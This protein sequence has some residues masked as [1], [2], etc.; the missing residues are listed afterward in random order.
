MDYCNS[1]FKY[2]LWTWIM[3]SCVHVSVCPC[4]LNAM[5]MRTE[6]KIVM[7]VIFKTLPDHMDVCLVSTWCVWRLSAKWSN[8]GLT[9]APPPNDIFSLPFSSVRAYHRS[10]LPSWL[11]KRWGRHKK[12]EEWSA[13]I[14]I[15]QRRRYQFEC[16]RPKLKYNIQC[17]E[18]LTW[19][20][21]SQE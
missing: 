14:W 16:Y 1:N 5:G 21:R 12:H 9:H 8:E 2:F 7:I 19:S 18:K 6:H 17:Y 15:L 13:R 20:H 10:H 4:R 11:G 3:W